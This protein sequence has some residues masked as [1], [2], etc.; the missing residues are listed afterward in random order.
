M[1][2]SFF[3]LQLTSFQIGKM[4]KKTL[5]EHFNEL[6][7]KSSCMQMR[8]MSEN[9]DFLL[10]TATAKCKKNFFTM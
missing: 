10:L 6:L 9:M 4:G 1:E 2:R 8:Y 7:Y 3:S 5:L